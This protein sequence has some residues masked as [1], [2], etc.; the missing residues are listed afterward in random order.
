M[1]ITFRCKRCSQEQSFTGKLWR[2]RL[3]AKCCGSAANLE[4]V[5]HRDEL[6]I[7]YRTYKKKNDEIL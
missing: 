2:M 6:P 7:S 5:N 4:L 3:A 1:T